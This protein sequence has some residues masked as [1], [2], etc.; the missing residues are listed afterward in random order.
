MAADVKE[1]KHKVGE[2]GQRVDAL[3]RSSEAREEELYSYRKKLLE[4]RDQNVDLRYHLEDLENCLRQ[5]NIRIKGVPFQAD[6][7]NLTDHVC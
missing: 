6:N 2:L 4:L 5:P 1:V 7:G 3:D